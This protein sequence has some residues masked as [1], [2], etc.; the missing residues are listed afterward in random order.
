MHPIF[1][2]LRERNIVQ[3]ALA[4]G[5]GAR[6]R[7][8][9]APAAR[10]I[11]SAPSSGALLTSMVLLTG[12]CGEEEVPLGP[13][14]SERTQCL[15][16][17]VGIVSW[18]PGD[19]SSR[20]VVGS[21]HM[22]LRNGAG[23]SSGMVDQAF[24]LGIDDFADAEAEGIGS[25][26]R[27]SIELWVQLNSLQYPQQPLVAIGQNKALVH[28]WDSRI[29]F[30]V[31]FNGAWQSVLAAQDLRVGEFYHV[32]ATYDGSSIALY[33]DGVLIAQQSRSDDT[34]SAESLSLGAR[35]PSL[36]GLLDEVTIY[37]RALDSVEVREIYE[38]G[39]TGKCVPLPS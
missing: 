19:G 39:E 23:Y 5:A 12:A 8:R 15:A 14:P 24:A 13:Y 11:P 35:S 9:S 28:R 29:D 10:M 26:Q 36:D 21:N 38:A 27:F 1:E 25:L 4:Y 3:W 31:S 30:S 2:R 34:S 20:D 33:V 32:A 7:G 22:T 6:V 37:D 16:P 18:W 17:P